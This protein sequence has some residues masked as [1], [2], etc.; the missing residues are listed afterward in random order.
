MSPPRLEG[1]AE[2]GGICVSARGQED[3]AG[4]LDLAFEDLGDQQLK[5]IA[6]PVRV[7]RV[8]ATLT[9]PDHA[10]DITSAARDWP[11]DSTLRR[12]IRAIRLTK[13]E[14]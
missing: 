1:L 12:Q 13:A 10:S 3:V 5:N 9:H 7:Y 14:G 2:P 4:R 11:P 8:R 6:P